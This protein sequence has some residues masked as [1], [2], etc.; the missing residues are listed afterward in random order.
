MRRFAHFGNDAIAY[1]TRILNF[2]R[3]LE[4]NQLTEQLFAQVNAH[5]SGKGLR[6]RGATVVT[7]TLIAAPT[8]AMKKRSDQRNA[9][10]QEEQ[11]VVLRDEGT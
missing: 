1:E 7:A 3:L 4:T 11:S 2:R 10:N 8:S 5:L 6:L 9:P